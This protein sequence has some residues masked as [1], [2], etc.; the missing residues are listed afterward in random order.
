MDTL[1]LQK[2]LFKMHLILDIRTT[3]RL[4][5]SHCKNFRWN[6]IKSENRQS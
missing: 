2:L 6:Y 5:K 3:S 4:Q 1:E